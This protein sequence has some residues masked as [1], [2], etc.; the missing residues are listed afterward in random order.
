M[1]CRGCGS[2][3]EDEART[4]F[5]PACGLE[6]VERSGRLGNGSRLALEDWGEVLLSDPL[7]RGGMGVVHRGWLEYNTTGRLAGT[8]AHPVAVKVL[9]SELRGSERART[10]FQ[11]EAVALGRLAHPNVVQFVCIAEQQG[12]LAIVMEFVQG[13]PLSQVIQSADLV[14]PMPSLP[15]IATNLC[16]HYFSQLLGALAA[17][18][19][20]GILHRDV[21][22]ANVLIRPDGVAKLTD[23]GIARLP[24]GAGRAT[25]GIVAGTGAYMSPEQ[26]RGDELDGRADLYS[27]AIVFYE[28]LTA[29]TPFDRTDRDEVALRTAQLEEAPPPLTARLP[30]LP[31]QLDVVMARALAKDR[32]HRYGSALELGEAIREALAVPTD[33]GWVAQQDFAAMARTIS[34]AMP[35]ISGDFV[36]EAQRLRTAMMKSAGS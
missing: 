1:R 26:V 33:P 15:C 8:P 20:L 22:P 17:V 16:W 36:A 32:R 6:V 21:K 7:G 14:R 18:H 19:A 23:F 30:A 25:G 29:W 11:R 28:M 4:R 9:L 3:I 31:R 13:A 12:Q 34:Q 5:C 10:M 24:E 27:A 2:T 35:G